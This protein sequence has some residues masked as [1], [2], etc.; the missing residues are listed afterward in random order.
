MVVRREPGDLCGLLPCCSVS[1][2]LTRFPISAV[3]PEFELV[4]VLVI[5]VCKVRNCLDADVLGKYGV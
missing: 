5:P 2:F 4:C 1:E 3:L